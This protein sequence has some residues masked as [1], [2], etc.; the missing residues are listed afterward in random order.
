VPTA[1]VPVGGGVILDDAEYVIT[2]P[3]KGEFK[4]FSSVCTHSG[5]LVSQISGNAI[6]CTCHRSEFSIKDGSVLK[7]PASR[8]LPETPTTVSGDSVFVRA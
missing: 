6:I 1:D 3:T 4:A 8:P 5:C 2:Q 7:P